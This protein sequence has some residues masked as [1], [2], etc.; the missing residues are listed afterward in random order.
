MKSVM[1]LPSKTQ[2]DIILGTILGDGYLEFNGCVGTRLQIKQSVR[3]KEYVFWMYKKLRNLCRTGP[4]QRPDTKQWY[5]STRA[6]RDLTL[7]QNI[8]YKNRKKRIPGDIADILISPLT[9]AVW[10]MDDGS[11]DFRPKS[12]CAI[13]LHTDSFSLVDVKRLQRALKSNFGIPTRLYKSLCRGKRY[14]KLYIGA[15]GRDRFFEVVKP[16]MLNCFASKLPPLQN[17]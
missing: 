10:Y 8:F 15:D 5:F 2:R 6:L 13:M 16:Y 9:L 3:H 17:T 1:I 14:P 11:L 7:T 4:K 12:H